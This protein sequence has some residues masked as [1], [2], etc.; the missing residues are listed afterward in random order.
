VTGVATLLVGAGLAEAGVVKVNAGS[1][2]GQTSEK[3]AISFKITGRSI[4]NLQTSIGYN[5]KCGQGGGPGYTISVSKMKIQSNGSYSAK[6]TLKGPVAAVKSSP[7]TLKG[8]ASGSTVT[9][10]IVDS[11]TAKFS[12]NGYTETFTAKRK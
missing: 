8:K 7:G 6:I 5:G 2:S 12:C 3:I 4:E 1:Y 9:G 10:K 11:S